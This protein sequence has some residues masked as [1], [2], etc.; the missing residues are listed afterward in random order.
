MQIKR[1]PEERIYLATP[2]TCTEYKTLRIRRRIENERFRA[3]TEVSCL[4]VEKG[5]AHFSPITQSHVQKKIAADMGVLFLSDFEF[6]RSFDLM[7]LRG[8]TELYVL[9]LSGWDTSAGLCVEIKEAKKLGM[10]ISYID[11][12]TEDQTLTIESRRE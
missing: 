11:Y 9:R 2:Y 3:V 10:D 7:M 4:L 5:I 1:Q 8:C 6:W 12:D